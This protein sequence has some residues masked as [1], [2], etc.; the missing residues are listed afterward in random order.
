VPKRSAH[1]WPRPYRRKKRHLKRV[2]FSSGPNFSYFHTPI[3]RNLY[4][5]LVQF[6]GTFNTIRYIFRGF[7]QRVSRPHN[8]LSV[9]RSCAWRSPRL[10]GDCAGLPV[11]M[12]LW[13]HRESVGRRPAGRT[14]R[15]KGGMRR[16]KQ[17][18]DGYCASYGGRVRGTAWRTGKLW[19][20]GR[21]HLGDGG[22]TPSPLPPEPIHGHTAAADRGAL[23]IG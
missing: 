16:L 8:P 13:S 15:Q 19:R 11:A 21:L 7:W 10:P 9:S 17:T 14:A 23:K 18:R 12:L 5:F 1:P 3:A 22:L 2:L 6:R 20:E 4:K